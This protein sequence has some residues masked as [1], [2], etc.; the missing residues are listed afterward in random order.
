[1]FSSMRGISAVSHACVV[2]IDAD[3]GPCQPVVMIQFIA[4]IFAC[5]WK[6]MFFRIGV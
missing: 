1:M 2:A 5:V 3:E 6:C 4:W